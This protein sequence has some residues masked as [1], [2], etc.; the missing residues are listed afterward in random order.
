MKRKVKWLCMIIVFFRVKCFIWPASSVL[1][2]FRHF[3]KVNSSSYGVL[4]SSVV[5]ISRK[6]CTFSSR[7]TAPEVSLAPFQ[8]QS[9]TN[10]SNPLTFPIFRNSHTLFYFSSQNSY[11]CLW[12]NN[13]FLP[14]NKILH[15]LMDWSWNIDGLRDLFMLLIIFFINQHVKNHLSNNFHTWGLI[16]IYRKWWCDWR[17]KQS[18]S[19]WTKGS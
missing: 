4:K 5:L 7:Q 13:L 19:R 14:Q 8:L 3:R 6:S 17:W 15:I 2:A 11:S 1:L 9:F 12:P 18:T 10:P 16:C